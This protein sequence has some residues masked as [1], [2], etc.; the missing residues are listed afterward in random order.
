MPPC[1]ASKPSGKSTALG[2]RLQ[3]ALYSVASNNANYGNAFLDVF[4]FQRE[5]VTTG[6]SFYALVLLRHSSGTC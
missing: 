5:T 3:Q 2:S 1:V 4:E 6:W